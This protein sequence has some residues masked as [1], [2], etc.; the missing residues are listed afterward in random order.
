MSLEVSDAREEVRKEEWRLTEIHDQPR[1][2]EI[3]DRLLK[4]LPDYENSLRTTTSL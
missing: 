1:V 4:R 2:F 3:A